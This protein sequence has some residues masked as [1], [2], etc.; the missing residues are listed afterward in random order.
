MQEQA[1]NNAEMGK[2]KAGKEFKMTQ[3]KAARD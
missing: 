2:K 1:R 3:M